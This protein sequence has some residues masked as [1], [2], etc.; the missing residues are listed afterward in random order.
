MSAVL[1]KRL[2]ERLLDGDHLFMG[3][4]VLVIASRRGCGESGQYNRLV[5]VKHAQLYIAT[6]DRSQ[7]RGHSLE[8]NVRG[9]A[10]FG[11]MGQG[12]R[13]KARRREFGDQT[14]R[15][16]VGKVSSRTGNTLN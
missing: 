12:E 10:L 11:K 2:D 9:I 14:G 7:R 13:F 8:R 5:L 6:A 16:F 4:D 1:R 3:D 15:F